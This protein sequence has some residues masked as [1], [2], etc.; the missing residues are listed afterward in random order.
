MTHNFDR[1]TVFQNHFVKQKYH[2]DTFV[3]LFNLKTNSSEIKMYSLKKTSVTVK[4]LSKQFLLRY[5]RFTEQKTIFKT[6]VKFAE[7]VKVDFTYILELIRYFC[8][9]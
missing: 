1:E 8:P 6:I 4:T 9:V 2:Q 7:L 3:L 5:N